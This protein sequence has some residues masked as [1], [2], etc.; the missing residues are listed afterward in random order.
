MPSAATG[1]AP[2]RPPSGSWIQPA[3]SGFLGVV[4]G[5]ASSFT[6][7]LAGLARVGASPAQAASGLFV[8]CLLIGVLAFGFALWRREPI[9]I[10]WST[11]GAALLIATGLPTG[12]YPAAVGAFL[13]AAALI[14]VAGLWPAFGRLVGAIPRSLASAMLAGILFTLCLAPVRAVA[15]MPALAAPVVLA[16]ALAWRFAR[17]YAVPL[18]F[19]VAAAAILSVAKFPAGLSALGPPALAFAVPVL[20]PATLGSLGLPLFIVTMASQN[21]P[22]LAVL[23][24]NGYRP[25]TGP[26]FVATGLGSGISALFGGVPVNLAAITAALCAGPE[27]HPDPAKRWYSTAVY[28]V[29]YVVVALC[30]GAATALVTAAP[31]LLIEAVAGLALLGSLGGA[32]TAAL[33]DERERLPAVVTFAVAASGVAA[34]GIGAPFWALAAG[35]ALLALDRWR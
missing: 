16:W 2:R 11:P 26:I 28:G 9:A 20:V 8:L 23:S 25:P 31:P 6:L 12:G 32:L 29:G 10:A 27:S 15:E 4:V 22:G 3:T 17:P 14:V 30:T 18:T 35:G 13:F 1:A 24:A 33:A 34:F 5:F 19:V 7:I 21:V